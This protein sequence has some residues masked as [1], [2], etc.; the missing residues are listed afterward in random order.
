MGK[1]RFFLKKGIRNSFFV[2]VNRSVLIPYGLW[3][4]SMRTMPRFL[5]LAWYLGLMVSGK[6][7]RHFLR[8]DLMKVFHT[9]NRIQLI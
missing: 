5:Q 8:R 3:D 1:G 2:A 7:Y 4:L 6:K 9:S